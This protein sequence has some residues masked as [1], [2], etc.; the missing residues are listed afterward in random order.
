MKLQQKKEHPNEKSGLHPRN[1]HCKRYKFSELIVTSP[2]LM[3]FVRLNDYQDESIDFSNP[4]AVMML[5]KALLK[6]FY[7]IHHWNLPSGYLCPPVPG[8]ADYLHHLADL[9]AS[10]NN[11]IIPV[12][13]KIKCL[14][15]GVGA[16]CIYPI[17]GHKEYGWSFIGSDIEPTAISSA[18]KIVQD[19]ISLKGKVELRL[20][21]HV[22][23]IFSGIIQKDERFDLTICNPPFH[24]SLQE[25]QSGTLRKLSNLNNKRITKPTLNFGGMNTELWCEGGE[26]KFAQKMI[27]ES[28]QFSRSCFW[29]STLI[30][31]SSNLKNVYTA[32][33]HANAIEV[34]TIPMSHGNKTSR[35]V[36][37]TFLTPEEQRNW[38]NTRWTN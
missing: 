7:D 34:K 5:N 11:E 36:A 2:E 29:F 1:R 30:S 31:K 22:K 16:N 20:Q 26:E 15:I 9:L 23:D 3:P 25:A 12:G 28:K 18:C 10:C 35:I 37:W 24:G 33:Q 14:D 13:T 21:Q 38:V 4:D 6:H 32:L 17:I 27:Y 19:N 8:R